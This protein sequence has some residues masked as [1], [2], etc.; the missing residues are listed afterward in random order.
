[1][2]RS[3]PASRSGHYDRGLTSAA[4]PAGLVRRGEPTMLT[5][6]YAPDTC[7]LGTHIALEAAGADFSAVHISFAAEEQRGPA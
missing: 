2:T 3:A 5:L 7:S 6:Y 4:E 1:M